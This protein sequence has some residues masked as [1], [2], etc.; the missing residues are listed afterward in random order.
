MPFRDTPEGQTNY[1]IISEIAERIVIDY[2]NLS[3]RDITHRA[4][5]RERVLKHLEKLRDSEAYTAGLKEGREDMEEKL[6]DII[7][8]TNWIEEPKSAFGKLNKLLARNT[9]K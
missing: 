6:K 4:E 1:D 9:P 3:G 2:A 7:I 5:F 8:Y